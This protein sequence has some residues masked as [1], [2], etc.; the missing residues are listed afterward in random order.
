MKKRIHVGWSLVEREFQ[1]GRKT[2]SMLWTLVSYSF[3]KTLLNNCL[4]HMNQPRPESQSYLTDVSYASYHQWMVH[5]RHLTLE[6]EPTRHGSAM[7]ICVS[8]ALFPDEIKSSESQ[9]PG[10]YYLSLQRNV[11]TELRFNMTLSPLCRRS[12][13]ESSISTGLSLVCKTVVEGVYC[14]LL[15]LTQRPIE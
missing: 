2:L 6:K 4:K 11:Y 8:P 7:I 13:Q 3:N 15:S 10:L 5:Q 12:I 1:E 14:N 9:V